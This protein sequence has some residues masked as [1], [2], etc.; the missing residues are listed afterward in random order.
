MTKRQPIRHA[1]EFW[2][3]WEDR[4]YTLK[5]HPLNQGGD[6]ITAAY[7]NLVYS[8]QMSF[9]DTEWGIVTH[10]WIRRHDDKAP[11]WR[12]MQR[13]KNELVGPE[14]V[15]VEVY[16]PVRELV[17]QA[18]M[19]HLW[20]FEDGFKLPFSLKYNERTEQEPA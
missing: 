1:R 15:A 3:N 17:D 7:V 4:S 9:E 19:Y 20:V 18:N 12:D 8:V 5:Y 11:I 6:I 16:P 2:G 10:L 13:I 14:L